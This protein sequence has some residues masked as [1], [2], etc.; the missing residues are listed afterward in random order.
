MRSWSPRRDRL[1]PR[2]DS[3]FFR[4]FPWTPDRADS[5]IRGIVIFSIFRG[6][7][8]RG[9]RFR[10]LPRHYN[11][12]GEALVKPAP[13]PQGDFLK[14]AGE[15]EEAGIRGGSPRTDGGKWG[16]LENGDV[17]VFRDEKQK[18]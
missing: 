9:L 18:R 10:S 8:A 12:G 15:P 2:R 1:T 16:R 14:G 11:H 5:F 6:G 13:G 4:V 7:Q 3:S 17:S